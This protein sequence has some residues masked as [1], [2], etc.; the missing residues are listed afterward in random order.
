MTYPEN[1]TAVLAVVGY[2]LGWRVPRLQ[3]SVITAS[4]DIAASII[5]NFRGIHS[6]VN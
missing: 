5:L 1:G 6:A 2:A 4:T 3:V